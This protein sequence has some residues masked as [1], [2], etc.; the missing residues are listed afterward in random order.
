MKHTDNEAF[1]TRSWGSVDPERISSY[2]ESLDTKT[3]F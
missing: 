2:A 3:T 1:W